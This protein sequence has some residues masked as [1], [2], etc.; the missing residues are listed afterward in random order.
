MLTGRAPNEN[1]DTDRT[2]TT[3]ETERSQLAACLSYTY[4]IGNQS[5]GSCPA[6]VLTAARNAD[7]STTWAHEATP[8]SATYVT[9]NPIFPFMLNK[10]T[11][12]LTLITP[13]TGEITLKRR[14]VDNRAHPRS[15]DPSVAKTYP[16][17]GLI[18]A[19][20]HVNKRQIIS[21]A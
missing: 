11:I 3:A 16:F 20:D 9:K 1:I 2:T 17:V 15:F 19:K 10:T 14:P 18:D 8:T 7:T 6:C 12:T 5:N 4:G 13:E 21:T